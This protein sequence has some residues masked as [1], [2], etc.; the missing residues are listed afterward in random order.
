[1]MIQWSNKTLEPTAAPFT[2]LARLQFRAAG[3]SGCGSAHLLGIVA[4]E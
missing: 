3:S 1:M 2:G 4:H